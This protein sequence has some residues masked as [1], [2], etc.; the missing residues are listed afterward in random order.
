MILIHCNAKHSAYNENS[1]RCFSGTDWKLGT[2]ET[3][4]LLGE[5]CGNVDD[6]DRISEPSDLQPATEEAA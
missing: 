1:T 3:D 5:N 4:S 6:V 2:V